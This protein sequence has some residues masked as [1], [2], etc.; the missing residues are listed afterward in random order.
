L[1]LALAVRVG[2]FAWVGSV[3]VADFCDEW[4]PTP[5]NSAANSAP[6]R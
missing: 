6:R 1:G 5:A 4:Q 2:A 3:V